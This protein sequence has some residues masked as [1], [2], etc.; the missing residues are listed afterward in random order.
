MNIYIQMCSEAT[1]IQGRWG[2]K[3]GDKYLYNESEW[4]MREEA[5]YDKAIMTWLPRIEDLI[6]MVHEKD[7]SYLDV[8]FRFDRFIN[9][10]LLIIPDNVNTMWLLFVMHTLYAKTWSETTW[11]KV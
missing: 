9:G 4:Y 6:E 2:P 11:E 5:C 7:K 8:L 3:T 1:E 10:S